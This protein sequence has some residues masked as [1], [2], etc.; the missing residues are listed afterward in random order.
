MDGGTA[1]G[2]DPLVGVTTNPNDAVLDP[3]RPGSN[4]IPIDVLLHIGAQM[5]ETPY[6]AEISARP[7]H[8][9]GPNQNYTRC[10]GR[11]DAPFDF[12]EYDLAHPQTRVFV[13]PNGQPGTLTE[14]FTSASDPYEELMNHID[15]SQ[16][17]TPPDAGNNYVGSWNNGY[18][19]PFDSITRNE[20]LDGNGA[21]NGAEDVNE[22]GVL[23]SLPVSVVSGLEIA[24]AMVNRCWRIPELMRTSRSFIYSDWQI[25]L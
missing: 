24:A 14:P 15:N 19:V 5:C 22:N 11:T 10:C 7:A 13:G 12:N 9:G 21:L 2:R 16:L 6:Q 8:A 20:D 23:D 3:A 17:Y 18:D 25:Q 4:A 1:L